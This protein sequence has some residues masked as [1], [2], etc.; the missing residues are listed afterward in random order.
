MSKVTERDFKLARLEIAHYI[1]R[2]I[3]YPLSFWIECCNAKA[4]GYPTHQQAQIFE[5]IKNNRYIS[6]RSGHGVGKT[7]AEAVLIWRHLICRKV[8]FQPMRALLTAPTFDTLNDVLWNEVKLVYGHLPKYF[9]DRFLVLS[10]EIKAI[11]TGDSSPWMTSARTGRAENSE[12]M[13]GFHGTFCGIYDEG[14][15]IPDEIYNVLEGSMAESD[16]SCFMFGNP[17]RT[18]GFFYDAH[19][20]RDSDWECLTFSCLDTLEH[21]TYSYPYFDPFG[22]REDIVVPGRVSQAYIDRMARKYGEESNIYAIRVLGEFPVSTD[23]VLIRREWLEKAFRREIHDCSKEPRVMGGDIA[24]YG[25]DDSCYVV[26]QGSNIEEVEK[27]HGNDPT[28]SADRIAGRC[29][30]LEQAN[31]KV[32]RIGVDVIG[33]GAGV[34]SNLRDLNLPA[35]PVSVQESSIDDGDTK[36]RRLRDWCWWKARCFFRDSPAC[37]LEDN[38]QTRQLADELCLPHYKFPGGRIEVENKDQMRKRLKRSP[39]MADAFVISR[40]VAFSMNPGIKKKKPA[41]RYH[42]TRRFR[43][44]GVE[45][46]KII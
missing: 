46:W 42:S 33:Y 23:E 28:E 17:T 26:S 35:F 8:P 13:Q 18:E 34:Y 5:A 6:V 30:E 31:K 41:E 27:W 37:F 38:D 20:E 22:K 15:A 21:E 25:Q 11:K 10:E 39:D 29:R 7:R 3:N 24:Y 1:N 45:E 19:T 16:A 4:H 14:S 43:H 32:D 40:R 36:C 12:A 44:Q 9:R 2:W